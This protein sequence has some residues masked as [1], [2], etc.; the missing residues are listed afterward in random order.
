MSPEWISAVGLVALGFLKFG[1]E[2]WEK[3]PPKNKGD[4]APP[5]GNDDEPPAQAA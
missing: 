3:R 5:K 4:S 2:V 1:Y